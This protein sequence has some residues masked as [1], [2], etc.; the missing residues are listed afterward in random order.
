M[1]QKK[2]PCT[3]DWVLLVEEHKIKYNIENSDEQIAE[4]SEYYF[5]KYIKKTSK[6]V[7]IY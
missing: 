4:M 7:C 2:S 1:A 6:T 5:K 3:G